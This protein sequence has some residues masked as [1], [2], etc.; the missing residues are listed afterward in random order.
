M[1]KDHADSPDRRAFFKNAADK[2]IEPVANYLDRKLTAPAQLRQIIRPPG[3]VHELRFNETCRRCG[4]CVKACPAEAIFPLTASFGEAEGTPAI[5]P[6]RSPCVVCEGLQCT[7]VCPSGALLPVYEPHLIAM[8][9]AEVY[10]PLCVRSDGKDCT[11]CVDRCPFGEV[12]IRFDD[13]GPPTV[14]EGCTGCGVCEFYCP[15]TP[16]AI[17]IRP[18]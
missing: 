4:E 11:E 14:A 15:T 7:H 2:L 10:T 17:T 16:K 13:S 8:G 5:D 1:T 9:L 3:S 18:V 12:A 6:S